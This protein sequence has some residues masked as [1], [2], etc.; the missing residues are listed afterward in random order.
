MRP[1]EGNNKIFLP[2]KSFWNG[3]CIIS[4]RTPITT[5]QEAI[6]KSF[7][8]S[9]FVL[10]LAGTGMV[11]AQSAN[12]AVLEKSTMQIEGTSTIHDWECEV[13]D[14]QSQ[15]TFDASALQGENK[16]TPVEALQLT[17]P[18]E[19]IE[20]GKGGMNKKIYDALK[21]KKYP[22]I[23][24]ELVSSELSQAEAGDANFQLMTNGKLTIAGKTREVSFPVDAV[25]EN[26][27]S[28]KFT[29]N[30]ELNMKDYD[31]D[32]PSAIFGTIKS[33]EKVTISFEF[34]IAQNQS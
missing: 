27:G 3:G 31:V 30:Y 7:L 19:K 17:I 22:N 20:S 13:Q 26:D 1:Y 12:Y 10:L 29:G 21:E 32:P 33:G 23:T 25:I 6:M 9:L 24:F 2:I 34:Y 8:T 11:M 15:V 4:N 16:S 28:Y 18:V 5:K 14:I